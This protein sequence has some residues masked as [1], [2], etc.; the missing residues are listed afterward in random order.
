M[1]QAIILTGNATIDPAIVATNRGALSY[2]VKPYDIEQL[3]LQ[4]QRAIE[5]Q[6][7]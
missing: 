6:E 3:L 4:I 7:A 2:L 1:T 5:E